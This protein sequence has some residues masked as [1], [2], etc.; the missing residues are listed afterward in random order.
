M[1]ALWASSPGNRRIRRGVPLGGGESPKL[2]ENNSSVRFAVPL[3]S[4]RPL[5]LSG[6]NSPAVVVEDEMGAS[7]SVSRV[8]TTRPCQGRST[9]SI[10]VRRAK[11]LSPCLFKGMN[12]PGLSA[13]LC[14]RETAAFT[15]PRLL[16]RIQY[17]ASGAVT[18]R[19]P[20]VT[21]T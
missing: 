20:T 16:V 6:G 10:P 18:G 9:G 19:L 7:S 3:L 15:R 12:N 5:K 11:A 4:L 14:Q 13:R 21:L 8:V 17:R 2:T 1:A